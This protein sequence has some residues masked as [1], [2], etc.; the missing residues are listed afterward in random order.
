MIERSYIDCSLQLQKGKLQ[1]HV[2][3]S[4]EDN[5]QKKREKIRKFRPKTGLSGIASKFVTN[6]LS[7][8]FN[9][10]SQFYFHF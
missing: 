2:K 3:N 6:S 10:S 8:F 7:Y 9:K 4:Y 1:F 5:K